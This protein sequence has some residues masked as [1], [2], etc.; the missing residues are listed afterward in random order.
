MPSL[1]SNSRGLPLFLTPG[2][3]KPD[4]P[5]SVAAESDYIEGINT[6][7]RYNYSHLV[8]NTDLIDNKFYNNINDKVGQLASNLANKNFEISNKKFCYF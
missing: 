1:V 4:Q 5:V 6:F 2:I 3:I 8:I 7:K